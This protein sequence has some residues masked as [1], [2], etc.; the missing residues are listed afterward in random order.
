MGDVSTSICAVRGMWRRRTC[1]HFGPRIAAG[2]AKELPRFSTPFLLVVMALFLIPLL[3][4]CKRQEKATPA[5]A[6]S[7]AVPAELHSGTLSAPAL[8]PAGSGVIAELHGGKLSTPE[9]FQARCGRA[10]SLVQMPSGPTLRYD[11]LHL[12][13]VFPGS[14]HLI[15]RFQVEDTAAGSGAT[16]LRN[17]DEAYALERLHCGK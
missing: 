1:R 13:V 4:G 12:L 5:V 16:T 2:S 11:S 17:V 14:T 7:G 8:A 3:G 9:S 6:P 10:S 15:P